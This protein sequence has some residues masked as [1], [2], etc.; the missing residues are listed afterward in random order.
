MSY[1]RTAAHGMM[2]LLLGLLTVGCQEP[3]PEEP[4]PAP[5][6]SAKAEPQEAPL[7][8]RVLHDAFGQI[9]AQVEAIDDAL[10]PVPLLRPAEE[11]ALKRYRNAEQL[12]RARQLGVDRPADEAAIE[13]LVQA[14]RLVRLEDG[15]AHYVVRDLDHS[16]PYLTPAAAALLTEVGERF[17]A[18]LA[19]MGLPPYRLEVTSVLRTAE[20]QADLRGSNVNAA[21]GVSTHE[22]G[23]TFDVAYSSVAAPADPL[24]GLDLDFRDAPWLEPYVQA[25]AAALLEAVAAR[26]SRELQAIL[27]KTLRALQ[28]EGAVMVTLEDLQPVYHM[29]V[30]RRTE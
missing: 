30:A 22:F 21:R 11:A 23:T 3:P 17:Q 1:T 9:E 18:R 28:D 25:M 13:R 20:R 4:L 16:A 2:A 6:A 24:A 12:A 15:T 14:G 8:E 7:A 27:G 29:T 26:R 5:R 10:H 19:E